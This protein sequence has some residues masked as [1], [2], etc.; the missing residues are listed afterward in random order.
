MISGFELEY[1]AGGSTID[2]P[3]E[4]MRVAFERAGDRL[5][6]FGTFVFPKLVPVFEASVDAQFSAQGHGP[7]NGA[8]A[9]LSRRYAEWKQR[10]YPG[11]G[12]LERSGALRS[13]LTAS[14]SPFAER[15][16]S[17]DTFKYG[18]RQLVYAG[19]HQTGSPFMP[20]RP[21]FDFDDDFERDITAAAEEGVRE[22][23]IASIGADDSLIGVGGG[24][25]S[26]E[27]FTGPRG[28][29]YVVTSGGGKRYL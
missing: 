25:G 8:W 18:T 10:H 7:H 16:I 3:F 23:L 27:V 1:R 19:V 24:G 11:K 26:G 29:R 5:A 2:Q 13:A 6:D 12:I 4:R 17:A 20:A 14:A 9:Q 28:G 22:S 21:P 15:E